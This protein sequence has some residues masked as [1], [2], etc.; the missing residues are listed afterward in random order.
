MSVTTR[1]Q[2][3]NPVEAA[4]ILKK[5]GQNRPISNNIINRYAALITAG[6]WHFNGAPIIIAADGTL[7]DG[8]H[9]LYALIKADKKLDLLIVR[10]LTKDAFSTIDIGRKRTGADALATIDSTYAKNRNVLVAAIK[11]I[12]SFDKDG[13][14]ND[15]TRTPLDYDDLIAFVTKNRK[16]MSSVDYTSQLTGAKKLA[17]HSSL[18][19]LHYLFSKKDL[20]QCNQFFQQFSSGEGLHKS[21]P[22]LLLR[23]KLID[24]H[25][26]GKGLRGR[27]AI[28]TIIKAWE[29]V[30][31]KKTVE[32][33]HVRND[34]VAKIV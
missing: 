30:R 27:D 24:A 23:A 34:Y 14:W 25:H 28:P 33:L 5:N 29:L 22:V 11:Y 31:E 26:Y 18:A 13:V 4:K 19:A 16:I 20:E 9:R 7:I 3:I 8:Q 12:V 15:T 10:G 21:H 17:T 1:V 6:K 2:T 32:Q